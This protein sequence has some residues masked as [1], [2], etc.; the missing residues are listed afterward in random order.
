MSW[1]SLAVVGRCVSEVPGPTGYYL[2][3]TFYVLVKVT[4]SEYS[5]H[6]DSCEV[7]CWR[8]VGRN[9]ARL[10]H[11][12]RSAGSGRRKLYRMPGML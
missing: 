6:L 3:V 7:G 1:R 11:R 10:G 12:V 8:A 2:S 9:V 4:V 5:H